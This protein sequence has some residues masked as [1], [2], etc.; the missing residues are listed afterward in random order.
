MKFH[1]I[2]RLRQDHG[3]LEK[4]LLILGRQFQG[5]R[6]GD[7][8]DYE[9]MHQILDYLTY[10]PDRYHHVREDLLFTRLAEKRPTLKPVL[11]TLHG[12]HH[13]LTGRGIRLRG[14]VNEVLSDLPVSRSELCRLGDAY[15]RAYREHLEYEEGPVIRQLQD[16]MSASDWLTLTTAVEWHADPLFAEEVSREY[17]HLNEKVNTMSA[18]YPIPGNDRDQICPVCSDRA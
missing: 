1:L 8:P 14:M 5:I 4:L 12:Q 9:L 7:R 18:G 11:R 6:R 13:D 3:N 2:N 16:T 15:V 10:Y 17:R